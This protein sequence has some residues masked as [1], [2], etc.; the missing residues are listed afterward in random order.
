MFL[1]WRKHWHWPAESH[2]RARTKKGGFLARCGSTLGRAWRRSA[3]RIPGL[4]WQSEL[5]AEG[6]ARVRMPRSH[7]HH[8]G[9]QIAVILACVLA[10]CQV[11]A[12][13]DP[14]QVELWQQTKCDK[15]LG[16][17]LCKWGE[18]GQSWFHA[19]TGA[20]VGK[21]LIKGSHQVENVEVTSFIYHEAWQ[22]LWALRGKKVR[23][24]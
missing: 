14:S 13:W 24:L 3:S 22:W 16:G 10:G 7:H 17:G 21:L 18:A 5:R 23:T 9:Q 20:G 6:C 2:W 11:Q 8:V 19:V 15:G 1:F 4:S 12:C